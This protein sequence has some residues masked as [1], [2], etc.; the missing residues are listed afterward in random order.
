MKK[1]SEE[2]KNDVLKKYLEG[3]TIASLSRETGVHENNLRRWKK[4]LVVDENGE[5]DREK[6]RLIKENR[7]LRAENEILKKFAAIFARGS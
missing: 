5:M 2:F 4:K 3:Q 7:E 6:L 1:Y